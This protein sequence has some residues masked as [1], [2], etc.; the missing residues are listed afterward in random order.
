MD[1]PGIATWAPGRSLAA[2]RQVL[3]RTAPGS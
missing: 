2:I 1:H 3:A